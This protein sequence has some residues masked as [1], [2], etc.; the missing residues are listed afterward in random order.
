MKF[1][2]EQ[3][4]SGWDITKNVEGAD[5]APPP[6]LLGLNMATVW[7]INIWAYPRRYAVS[8][9]AEWRYCYR[10]WV[11]R[12]SRLFDLR[13]GSEVWRYC[14]GTSTLPRRTAVS[15]L[16][17]QTNTAEGTTY[18]WYTTLFQVVCHVTA[19]QVHT[20]MNSPRVFKVGWQRPREFLDELFP[21]RWSKIQRCEKIETL[22]LC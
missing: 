9:S 16:A 4:T 12:S 7:I 10:Y 8:S 19:A 17:V 13:C 1:Q 14:V 11:R 22:N 18:Q 15:N 6:A 20:N 2:R 3:I 5:S 21:K